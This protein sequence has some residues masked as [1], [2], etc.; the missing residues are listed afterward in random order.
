M[1]NIEEKYQSNPH[2]AKAAPVISTI[3]FKTGSTLTVDEATGELKVISKNQE[4]QLM[5]RVLEE[6]V[7]VDIITTELNINA[8]EQLNLSSKKINIDASEQLNIKTGGNLVIE[9]EKDCLTEIT[10]TNK[11]IAKIQKLTATLGNVELKANDDIKLDGESVK[12]N[13]EE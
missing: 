12:L 6:G 13:C 11:N 2:L 10:G 4:L 3:K 8:T 5:I 1:K 9:A 7:I